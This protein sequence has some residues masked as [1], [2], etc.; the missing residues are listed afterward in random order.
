MSFVSAIILSH[1]KQVHFICV[2]NSKIDSF[3]VVK[4]GGDGK[5]KHTITGG[6][7]TTTFQCKFVNHHDHHHGCVLGIVD[8]FTTG[9]SPFFSILASRPFLSTFTTVLQKCT[10]W[11]LHVCLPIYL[12]HGR[13]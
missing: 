2:P 5:I 10:Y 11:L 1:G 13:A 9:P 3:S 8:H 12:C 7:T 4:V 6:I